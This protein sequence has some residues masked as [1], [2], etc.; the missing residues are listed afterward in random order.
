MGTGSVQTTELCLA[1]PASLSRS[2]QLF[3][4]LE[5]QGFTQKKPLHLIAAFLPQEFQLFLR[6]HAF[7]N[8]FI[9]IL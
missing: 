1:D 4:F 9:F 3:E 8:D 6:L 2:N 7:G 5:R